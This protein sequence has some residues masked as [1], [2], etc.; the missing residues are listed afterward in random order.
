MP[1]WPKSAASYHI[2]NTR[3]NG[4]C[5]NRTEGFHYKHFRNQKLEKKEVKSFFKSKVLVLI[6]CYFLSDG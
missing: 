1:V 3:K 5:A 4:F 2:S 6:F